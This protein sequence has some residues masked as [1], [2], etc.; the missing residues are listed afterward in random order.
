VHTPLLFTRISPAAAHAD[1]TARFAPPVPVLRFY[2]QGL[3]SEVVVSFLNS[4]TYSKKLC[5]FDFSNTNCNMNLESMLHNK[6]M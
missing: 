5:Y 2:R 4:N 3:N 1:A 6:A